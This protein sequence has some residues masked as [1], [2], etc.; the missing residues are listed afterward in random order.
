MGNCMAT[1]GNIAGDALG[2]RND[3][4]KAKIIYMKKYLR[5]ME[6]FFMQSFA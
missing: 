3:D 1:T 2:I 4:E 5:E 6:R